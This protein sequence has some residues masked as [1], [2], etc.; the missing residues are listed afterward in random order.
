M[1]VS[2][3][4]RCVRSEAPLVGIYRD[5]GGGCCELRLP[6]DDAPVERRSTWSLKMDSVEDAVAGGPA[7][8]DRDAPS[9]NV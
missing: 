7:V 5:L 2:V 9:Q 4:G 1:S 8:V 3:W 6:V